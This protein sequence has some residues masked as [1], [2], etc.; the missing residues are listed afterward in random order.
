MLYADTK[1]RIPK[2]AI[3]IDMIFYNAN[4]ATAPANAIPAP[5]RPLATAPPVKVE[6][7]ADEV[8]DA[9]TVV[10]TGPAVMVDAA[11]AVTT[12]PSE[13]VL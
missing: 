12:L 1:P 8:P 4:N 7:G 3:S 9:T 11:L 13:A 6:A 2:P 5:L 10:A